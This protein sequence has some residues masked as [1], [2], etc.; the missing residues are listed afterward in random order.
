MP[1]I[2]SSEGS[3]LSNKLKTQLGSLDLFDRVVNLKLYISAEVKDKKA[4][5]V[6]TLDREFILRSDFEIF[7]PSM[8]VTNVLRTGNFPSDKY[9][10]R[11]CR[12]KPSIKVQYN[13]I[14]GGKVTQIDFF[15]SN[16]YML[17]SDGKQV[18]QLNMKDYKLT[19][20]DCML[21]YYNQ[22]RSCFDTFDDIDDKWL[23]DFSPERAINGITLIENCIPLYV[24]TDKLP[25]DYDLH[26]RCL[27]GNVTRQPFDYLT[28]GKETYSEI[29]ATGNVQVFS[30]DGKSDAQRILYRYITRRFPNKNALPKGT[31]I[32]LDDNGCMSD[33]DAAKYGVKCIT[34]PYLDEWKISKIKGS[35]KDTKDR[36]LYAEPVAN[37]IESMI[38]LISEMFKINLA[39]KSLDNGNIVCYR[40]SEDSQYEELC[41]SLEDKL[42]EDFKNTPCKFYWQNKLPAVYNITA[43]VITMIVC[44][45]FFTVN[46]FQVVQFKN[47]YALGTLTSYITDIQAQ[48]MSFLVINSQIAF[49][50]VEDLNE[51]QIT[52]VARH[53]KD[54]EGEQ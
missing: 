49:A 2:K 46:P 14:S 12:Y 35:N 50:T 25:P 40:Q 43:D 42:I 3:L 1:E 10:I 28:E 52:C 23:F 7:Y 29:N 27:V 31:E 34:S 17:G 21:G 11:K 18:M 51:M 36:E 5:T 39:Y 13:Q 32:Q 22:F 45:F 19:R 33:E 38:Q 54:G 20:V 53:N 44:P 41:K 9:I 26:I 15:I 6:T 16:F 8:S 47:R 37:C 30:E 4:D 24:G 48:T